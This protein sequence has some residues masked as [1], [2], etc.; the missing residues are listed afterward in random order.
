MG[1]IKEISI[2]DDRNIQEIN[3]SFLGFCPLI[4]NGAHHVCLLDV[5]E[6]GNGKKTKK[7]IAATLTEHTK[8]FFLPVLFFQILKGKK[9]PQGLTQEAALGGCCQITCFHFLL[10]ISYSTSRM[11]QNQ[12]ATKSVVWIFF[13]LEV[14]HHQRV[15]LPKVD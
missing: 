12:S 1:N 4:S 10:H 13:Q 5:H 8:S 11:E 9:I 2:P 6:N 3:S 7:G 14:L 15:I